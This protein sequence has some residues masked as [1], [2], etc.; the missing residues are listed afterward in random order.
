MSALATTLPDGLS[1]APQAAFEAVT[2]TTRY[3]VTLRQSPFV[4]GLFVCGDDPHDAV[5][6][7]R[8]R[9]SCGGVAR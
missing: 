2:G 3:L 6:F 4:C 8:S 9:S 7:D 1:L 5:R